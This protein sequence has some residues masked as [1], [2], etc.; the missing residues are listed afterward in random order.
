MGGF[1]F[2]SGFTDPDSGLGLDWSLGGAR[3]ISFA[4][5]VAS[6]VST[7]GFFLAGAGSMLVFALGSDLDSVVGATIGGELAGAAGSAAGCVVE[8]G[9]LV[10]A[11]R[12]WDRNLANL[13]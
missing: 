4:K 3:P 8:G 5:S 1:S 7:M 6:D 12:S 9:D 2:E 10:R 13:S 11:F